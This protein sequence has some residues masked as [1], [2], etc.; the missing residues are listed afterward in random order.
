MLSETCKEIHIHQA[1]L[2]THITFM[3]TLGCYYR[4]EK[5]NKR[6]MSETERKQNAIMV[7]SH[8]N[9]IMKWGGRAC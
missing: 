6:Q 4:E 7:T 2:E 8:K 9:F 3:N 1:C 5:E